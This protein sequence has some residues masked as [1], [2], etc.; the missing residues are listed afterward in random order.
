MSSVLVASHL[1]VVRLGLRTILRQ[2]GISA[3]LLEAQTL[4]DAISHISTELELVIVDPDM[5]EMNPIHFVQQLRKRVPDLPIVFFGGKN[6]RLF[7]SLAIKLGLAGYLGQLSDEATIAATIR[8][9]MGG[10]QCIPRQHAE[11]ELYG[12]I[13]ALSEKELA[14]LLL[15]RQ[16]LRNKE[17]AERLYLSEKT[18]SAH[19]RNILHKLNIRAIAQFSEADVIAS[20]V[21]DQM[22]L[23]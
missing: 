18:I 13:Q 23:C 2:A 20:S 21:P 7:A 19:K 5:P 8:T 16:G 9:V 12:R 17:I 1:P 14:V 11:G 15:L 10:M 6:P 3:Q 4:Q 22:A